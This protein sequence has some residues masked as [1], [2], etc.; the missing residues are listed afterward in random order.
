MQ[1][2]QKL[3]PQLIQSLQLL[4]LPL[5]ELEQMIRNELVTNP[6]LEENEQPP[7][8][9]SPTENLDEFVAPA[10]EEKPSVKEE[11]FDW[12]TYVEAGFDQE[13]YRR[14]GR[15]QAEDSS[16][17]VAEHLSLTDRLL[18]QLRMVPLSETEM[19]IGEQIIGNINEDGYL[20]VALDDIALSLSVPLARAEKV[21]GVIQTFEPTGIAARNLQECLLIQ[22]REKKEDDPETVKVVK[23]HLDDLEKRHFS[24]IA[25]HLAIPEERVKDVI[26]KLSV[27]N[28]KPGLAAAEAA[29]TIIPDVI[30]EKVDGE[31]TVYLNDKSV[32][33]LRINPFYKSVIKKKKSESDEVKKFVVDKL[34]AARWLIKAIQQRRNTILRVA[35]YI[36]GRQVQFFEKGILHLQPMIMQE[37]AD[38][39]SMHVATISRVV[40]GKYMQTPRGIFEFKY[41]FSIKIE[42]EDQTG[43]SAKSVKERIR[44]L[45]EEEDP[46]HT[47]SDQHIVGI[48]K[49]E[50]IPLARRTVAKYRTQ[51]N[52][53]PARYRKKI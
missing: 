49:K 46:E 20:G 40:D 39:I 21:L 45:I 47:L 6:F 10:T 16:L 31:Y 9:E 33:S 15:E 7:E 53:L 37:A 52:I 48:L 8:T 41:F 36:V 26:K 12:D 11:K 14:R 3:T 1:L 32:P 24:A 38:A 23:D 44:E 4:Q 25:K 19:K 18:F 5:L 35:N 29:R 34:N 42:A 30:V 2:Q 43:L 50:G 22:L 13:N 51:L 17:P 27:L 28:P